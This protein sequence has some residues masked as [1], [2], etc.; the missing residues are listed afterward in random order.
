MNVE[1][2]SETFSVRIP[3]LIFA[4]WDKNTFYLFDTESRLDF[5]FW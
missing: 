3:N 1:I 4:T 5:S 2:Y